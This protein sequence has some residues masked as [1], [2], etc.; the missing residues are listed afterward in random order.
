MFNLYV[1]F[2]FS[3]FF[4]F[5]LLSLYKCRKTGI[6]DKLLLVFLI[7]VPPVAV[8]LGGSMLFTF[9]LN[10]G[11]YLENSEY[12]LQFS[13][14]ASSSLLGGL[15]CILI[16]IVYCR[17][18]K[19]SFWKF[20]DIVAYGLFP[21]LFIA[22]LGCFFNGCCGGINTDIFQNVGITLINRHPTQIYEGFG[23][24][25][26]FIIINIFL[27]R[28]ADGMLF[29]IG[30]LILYDLLRLILEPLRADTAYFFSAIPIPTVINIT[31]LLIGL[32]LF[33]YR[34]SFKSS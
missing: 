22:R 28:A 31:V 5:L 4:I 32:V 19:I 2:T 11:H 10:P 3:G 8:I 18:V 25:L 9:L 12:L 20:S 33:V 26:I 21:A 6:P 15:S 30:V 13:N 34:Y 1:A 14:L 7:L 24:L 27:K 17:I 16:M 23:A 29:I